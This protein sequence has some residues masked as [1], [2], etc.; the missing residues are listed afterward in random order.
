[1]KKKFIL[2]FLILTISV[3]AQ[4]KKI[5]T[6]NIDGSIKDT[7]Y[8]TSEGK[9]DSVWVRYNNAG[10]IVGTAQ[11]SNGIKQGKWETFNDKG[12]KLYEIVYI[13]GFKKFGKHWDENGV[14]I[15]EKKY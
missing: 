11:F 13:D 9:K 4:D 14:L 1:M 7:G 12:I 10:I 6:K 2:L 5:V 8:I 3:S 15:E